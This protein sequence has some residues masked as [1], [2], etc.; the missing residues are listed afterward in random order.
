MQ[1]G[2]CLEEEMQRCGCVMEADGW[3]HSVD[4]EH[5]GQ[6][7]RSCSTYLVVPKIQ[8]GECLEEEMQRCECVME[9]DGWSHLVD[10]ERIG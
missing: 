8:T 4:P 10:P 2:K 3:S 9:A 6:W 1:S 7:S 5:I